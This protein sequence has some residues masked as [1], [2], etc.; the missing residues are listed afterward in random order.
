MLAPALAGSCKTSSSTV[1][2]NMQRH[3]TP[4]RK[5]AHSCKAAHA[6][7]TVPAVHTVLEA[8]TTATATA[9]AGHFG[10]DNTPHTS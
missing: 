4:A 7:K 5:A 3:P 6:R 1:A 8:H 10:Y 2:E 9:A